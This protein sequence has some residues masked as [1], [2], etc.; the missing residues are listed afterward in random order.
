MSVESGLFGSI[1]EAI[2]VVDRPIKVRDERQKNSRSFWYFLLW[3][4]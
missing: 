3:V 1:P 4:G 2:L